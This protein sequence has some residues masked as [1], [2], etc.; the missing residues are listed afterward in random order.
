MIE[1]FLENMRK[2]CVAI[3]RNAS[4]KQ[5]NN[6]KKCYVSS[7]LKS[8]QTFRRESK[9]LDWL[10]R[11]SLSE[12][13]NFGISPAFDHV[14]FGMWEGKKA[15]KVKIVYLCAYFYSLGIPGEKSFSRVLWLERELWTRS[16]LWDS[17]PSQGNFAC[18]NETRFYVNVT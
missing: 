9:K 18:L 2:K 16:F 6:V 1:N 13:R 7:I 8:F 17:G 4:S 3:F 12:W 14:R 15:F 11:S 5:V 10:I